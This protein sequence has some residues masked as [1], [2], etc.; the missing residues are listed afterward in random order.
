MSRLM[1]KILTILHKCRDI[2]DAMSQLRENVVTLK[3]L[4]HN[5]SKNVAT[6]IMVLCL[7]DD[8]MSRL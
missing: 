5:S 2:V 8:N 1:I 6:P 7:S 4:C 3:T